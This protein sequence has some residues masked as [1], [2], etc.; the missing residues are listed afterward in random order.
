MT[1]GKCP[2]C[3]AHYSTEEEV[4]RHLGQVAHHLPER[5]DEAK[6]A[7]NECA[8]QRGEL[9]LLFDA[10]VCFKF[11][12]WYV[13]HIVDTDGKDWGWVV[14]KDGKWEQEHMTRDQAI[15]EAK[16]RAGHIS[17]CG[18]CGETTCGGACCAGAGFEP[19][20]RTK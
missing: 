16:L 15:D 9:Q 3:N 7:L 10:A 5:L 20:Q 12:E 4:A 18:A 2:H 13:E 6:S 14:S 11:G 17:R 8:R 1:T 19:S